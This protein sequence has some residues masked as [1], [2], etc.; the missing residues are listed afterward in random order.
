MSM[1]P[2]GCGGPRRFTKVRRQR[3]AAGRLDQAGAAVRD[4]PRQQL[5]RESENQVWSST[6]CR[7]VCWHFRC[8]RGL[9]QHI[10]CSR[11]HWQKFHSVQARD[12]HSRWDCNQWQFRSVQA[13]LR[14][15]L[16]SSGQQQGI[17]GEGTPWR[18]RSPFFTRA[19]R[20]PD[21]AAVRP[22][23]WHQHPPPSMRRGAGTCLSRLAGRRAR[24]LRFRQPAQS[25]ATRR[26][27]RGWAPPSV[28]QRWRP[29]R[30]HATTLGPGSCKR[31]RRPGA[32][33]WSPW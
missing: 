29:P 23:R 24:G 19:R 2:D 6:L 32:S 27:P 12:L 1:P 4:S 14:M 26:R 7:R 30:V 17:Q 20:G 5:H 28:Q 16:S 25:W 15:L 13:Q 33:H 18:G 11:W 21:R 10:Q 9:E 8:T 22:T 31:S 3:P